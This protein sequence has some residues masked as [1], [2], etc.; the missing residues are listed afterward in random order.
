VW[1]QERKEPS[2]ALSGPVGVVSVSQVE[3]MSNVSELKSDRVRKQ[4]LW[5]V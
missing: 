4:T 5:R 1:R 3:L 2:T